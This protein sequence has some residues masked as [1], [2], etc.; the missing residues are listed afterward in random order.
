MAT[1][2]ANKR[3]SKPGKNNKLIFFSIEIILPIPNKI[4]NRKKYKNKS[5]NTKTSGLI[6]FCNNGSDQEIRKSI[7]WINV[8]F[9][10]GLR[11]TNLCKTPKAAS[12]TIQNILQSMTKQLLSPIQKTE[13]KTKETNQKTTSKGVHSGECSFLERSKRK[14]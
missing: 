5:K 1:K 2:Q 14:T 7:C 6:Y 11:C 9:N 4:K 8:L 12:M 3:K 13:S 10:S